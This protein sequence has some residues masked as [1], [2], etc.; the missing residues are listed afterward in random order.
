MTVLLFS[1]FGLALLDSINPSALAVT[2]Y[3]LL[4]G[5]PF[6]VKVLTYVGAVF[7]SYIVLG[8]LIM[9]GLGSVRGY[10]DSP[11]AY[12]AQGVIGATL[13]AYAVFAPSKPRR[14]VRAER[15]PRS[16]SLGAIYLLGVTVT[17][18]E[19]STAF[20]YLGAVA[21]MTKAG[22]P[23]VQWLPIL[24]VYNV[25]FVLPPLLLLASYSLF[26]ERMESRFERLR[27]R[28]AKGSRE[29]MLW[30]LGIVG[31]LLLADSLVFFDFFGVPELL[32][33][34]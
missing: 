18:V 19:F 14:E 5:R 28:F 16:L 29:T 1:L 8:V 34:T 7:S 17:V 25:V 27:E 6:A 32:R 10:L 33:S 20:P 11:V 31:F 2:I 23:V 13:L 30:I 21:L 9:L 24:F 26:G 3:L 12:V 15:Q 22:L 4:T